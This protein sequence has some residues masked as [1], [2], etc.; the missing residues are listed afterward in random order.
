ME[1]AAAALGASQRLSAYDASYLELS[2]RRSV[3]LAT[4]TN[5][6]NERH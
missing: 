4:L 3:P 2:L 5:V 1:A 6:C